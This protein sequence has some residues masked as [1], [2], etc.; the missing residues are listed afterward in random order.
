MEDLIAFNKSNKPL[1]QAVYLFKEF[2][3]DGIRDKIPSVQLKTMESNIKTQI[4]IMDKTHRNECTK[5]ARKQRQRLISK[6]P[7]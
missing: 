1:C 2:S 7:K 5:Q 4:S 6:R 3:E